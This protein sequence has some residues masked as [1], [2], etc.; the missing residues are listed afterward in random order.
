MQLLESSHVA[1][2]SRGVAATSVVAHVVLLGLAIRA[3]AAAADRFAEPSPEHAVFFTPPPPAPPPVEARPSTSS[4]GP[5]TGPAMPTMPAPEI[6]DVASTELPSV[7]TPLADPS[8]GALDALRDAAGGLPT[9]AGT[10]LASPDGV[11]SEMTVER[12]VVAIPGAVPR[13][14]D[15]LRGAGLEGRVVARFVVDTAGRVEAGSVQIVSAAHPAFAEAVRRTLPALRF[16]AAEAGGRR[17]RQL[18]DMP[19]DFVLTR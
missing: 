8:R 18:V 6:P 13:Y 10:P 3:T 12:A 9:G 7:D 19:F 11:F 2:R 1:R 15:A 17:V 16:R 14:P 5:A 4:G